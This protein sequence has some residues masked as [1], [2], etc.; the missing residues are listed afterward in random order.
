MTNDVEDA[1]EE[2]KRTGNWAPVAKALWNAPPVCICCGGEDD[3]G[4]AD[5]W[6]AYSVS[7]SMGPDWGHRSCLEKL[8]DLS[9]DLSSTKPSKPVRPAR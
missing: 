7:C 4:P 8:Y 3:R 9:D 6:E 1:L 2:Y 5:P